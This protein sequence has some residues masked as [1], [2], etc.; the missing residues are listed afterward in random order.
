V[1][2]DISAREIMSIDLIKGENKFKINTKNL[3]AG[4]Y[5]YQIGV[6][7]EDKGKIIILE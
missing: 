6:K 5:F 1:L 4:I 3:K 2:Y 7:A